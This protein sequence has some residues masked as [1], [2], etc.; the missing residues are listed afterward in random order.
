M[1]PRG[2]LKLG[3]FSGVPQCM[4]MLCLH[5]ASHHSPSLSTTRSVCACMGCLA[6]EYVCLVQLRSLVE[7]YGGEEELCN[8][9]LPSLQDA[10]ALVNQTQGVVSKVKIN[11]ILVRLMRL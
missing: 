8:L 3:S 4:V 5:T 11:G 2:T 10:D 1:G 6:S 9:L 7:R